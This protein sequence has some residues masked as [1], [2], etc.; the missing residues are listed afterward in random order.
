MRGVGALLGPIGLVVTG[1]WT[2]AEMANPAY[3]VT[4]PCV[5]QIAYMRQKPLSRFCSE[6]HAPNSLE[7]KFCAQCGHKLDEEREQ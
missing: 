1:F 2:L 4:V 6:C 5:I 7:A 3:R